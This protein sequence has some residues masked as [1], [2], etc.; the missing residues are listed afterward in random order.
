MSFV[1]TRCSHVL[2]GKLEAK[3][4]GLCAGGRQEHGS[5]GWSTGRGAISGKYHKIDPMRRAWNHCSGHLRL[6]GHKGERTKEIVHSTS[7]QP[8]TTIH[9]EQEGRF[10]HGYYDS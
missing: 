2:A 4:F 6:D 8:T 7:T 3:T 1:T 9:G 10:F 5:T